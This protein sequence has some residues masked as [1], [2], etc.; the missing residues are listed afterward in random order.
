MGGAFVL[1]IAVGFF[2]SYYYD[3]QVILYGAIIFSLVTNFIAYF[4]SDKV[5]LAVSKAKPASEAEYSELH[6][7]VE[8]LAIT[9]G[10][11]KPRVYIINDAAPNAFATG[12]NPKHS[13][14]AFTTGL[15]RMLDRSEIEG[16]TAHE[17]AHIKNRDILVSTVAV[18]LAGTL[19]LVA[20]FFL[21]AS[22][23]GGIGGRNREN[24]GGA[25]TAIIAVLLVVLAPIAATIIRLAISRK[26]EFLADASGALLTRYP[27]GLASALQK[28]SGYSAPLKSA[29]NATAHLFIANPFGG[30]GKAMKGIAKL[31]QTHPPTEERVAA[32]LGKGR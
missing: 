17:L 10:I 2:L 1:I 15:L 22:L 11:L 8:N 24:N 6:N 21:R 29:S 9:A 25:V 14:V 20:D 28:I 12:R 26:R 19:A 31:F 3:S 5:A 23:F 13:A 32:L 7:I 18:V 30:G 16:V 27:E 4:T